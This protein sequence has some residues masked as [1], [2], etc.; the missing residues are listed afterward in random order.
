M[1]NLPE[2]P[3]TLEAI[4]Q[5]METIRKQMAVHKNNM[6]VQVKEMFRAPSE[7]DRSSRWLNQFERAIAIY[8][9]VM[10]GVKVMRRVKSSLRVFRK[11]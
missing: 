1:P 3:V 11:K 7:G 8:D 10:F 2:L 6:Q 9:G 4:D 5:E